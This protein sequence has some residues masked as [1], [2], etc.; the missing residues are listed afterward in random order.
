MMN[1]S[2]LH[3]TS[4]AV[5]KEQHQT[6][7]LPHGGGCFWFTQQPMFSAAADCMNVFMVAFDKKTRQSNGV[8]KKKNAVKIMGFFRSEREF[9]ESILSLQKYDRCAYQLIYNSSELWYSLYLDLEWS[10]D[11][12]VE[13]TVVSKLIIKIHKLYNE[14]QGSTSRL[15]MNVSCSSRYLKNSYHIIVPEIIFSSNCDG[16]MKDFAKTLMMHDDLTNDEEFFG[17]I[18]TGVY[19]KNRFFRAVGCCKRNENHYLRRINADMD[20][21]LTHVYEDDDYTQWEHTNIIRKPNEGELFRYQFS[22]VTSKKRKSE[23]TQPSMKNTKVCTGVD[24]KIEMPIH[25][26]NIFLGDASS[27]KSV[28]KMEM[29]IL[30]K[31]LQMQIHSKDVSE[32][33]V[34]YFYMKGANVCAKRLLFGE[35]HKHSNNNSFAIKYTTKDGTEFVFV[36]CLCVFDSFNVT[37]NQ[38]GILKSNQSN[39]KLKAL[40]VRPFAIENCPDGKQR[41]RIMDLYNR[42]VSNFSRAFE[43]DPVLRM[44]WTSMIP[45]GGWVCIPRWADVASG[46]PGMNIK[47]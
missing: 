46:M 30:P 2:T 27:I 24:M 44:Q 33:D 9:H 34:S 17:K 26:K 28:A 42:D 1:P 22:N 45:L 41:N 18:D 6:Y 25:F 8:L 19:T 15:S 43:I 38:N 11:V 23:N 29:A 31:I 4:A 10:G 47:K 36:K 7:G 39:T 20:D 35:K 40:I 14:I 13:H 32:S 21:L 3:R 37:M 5:A 16:K 12:D